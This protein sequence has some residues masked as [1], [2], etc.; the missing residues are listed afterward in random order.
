MSSYPIYQQN[1]SDSN[2][3]ILENRTSDVESPPP[4]NMLFQSAMDIGTECQLMN[5]LPDRMSRDQWVAT[6]LDSQRRLIEY[7]NRIAHL[8]LEVRRLSRADLGEDDKDGWEKCE[9]PRSDIDKMAKEQH[10]AFVVQELLTSMERRV[11]DLFVCSKTEISR[12]DTAPSMTDIEALASRTAVAVERVVDLWNHKTHFP[13]QISF[14]SF[15]VNDIALFF[16]STKGHYMAFNLNL[17]NYFLSAESKALIGTSPFFRKE[18]VLG[19][20]IQ[21]EEISNQH[22]VYDL[23]PGTLLHVMSVAAL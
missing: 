4:T 18:Y 8:E 14:T 12:A 6:A 3:T 7:R 20:I 10:S 17:P 5:E 23:K 19:R 11:E 21:I 13:T 9:V 2:W 1:D 22:E 15:A 16:P